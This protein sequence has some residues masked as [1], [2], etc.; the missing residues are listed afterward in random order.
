MWPCCLA[1]LKAQS[2]ASSSKRDQVSLIKEPLG[3]PVSSGHCFFFFLVLALDVQPCIAVS[4][5]VRC[6]LRVFQ[7]VVSIGQVAANKALFL[8]A[9]ARIEP[10]Q[11]RWFAIVSS[12]WQMVRVTALLE[13]HKIIA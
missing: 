1:L 2:A 6:P 4:A 12:F 7:K 10:F 5:H 13:R 11:R 8:N 9:Q 3:R